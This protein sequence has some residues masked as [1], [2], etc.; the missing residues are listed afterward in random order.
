MLVDV[1]MNNV[2]VGFM[3]TDALIPAIEALKAK[4][5]KKE[6]E[7]APLRQQLAEKDAEIDPLRKML[8]GLCK[9]AGLP[10]AYVIQLEE[11][12]VKTDEIRLKFRRD[13]FFNKELSQAAVDFLMAKKAADQ[14]GNPTPATPDEIYA[15]ITAHGY[16]FTGSNEANN[17]V[18]LKTALTR[19]TS[20]IAKITDDLYGLRAW[21][22]MRAKYKQ[23]AADGSEPDA[24]PET[25]SEGEKPTAKETAN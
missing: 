19:N 25:S 7:I 16:T 24:P 21:Y 22:G 23:R 6:E 18:A 8:N 10:P 9:E 14:S 11:A 12:G 13:Q 15:A 17:K 3:E 2:F 5:A 4:V 1:A 20:Q